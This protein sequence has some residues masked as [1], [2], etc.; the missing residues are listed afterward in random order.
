LLATADERIVLD[1]INAVEAAVARLPDTQRDG[2]LEQINR[3][4]GTI[5]WTLRTEYADR[6]T[7]AHE[8]L[9][10]LD[11]E[12]VALQERYQAFVRLRQ[13]SVHSYLGY[14]DGIRDLRNRVRDSIER[15][16]QL[17]KQQG[18]LIEAVAVTELTA[19]SER[20]KAYQTQAR[21]AVADSFDRANQAQGAPAA[22]GAAAGEGK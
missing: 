14:D 9:E 7:E 19:R 13:A 3:L 11:A 1:R 10:E 20:L 6:L 8:H 16:G 18:S 2:H 4:R 21:Y 12:I 5:T 15:V 17:Q 22:P